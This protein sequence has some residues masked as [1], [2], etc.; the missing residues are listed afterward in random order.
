MF[1]KAKKLLLPSGVEAP[2]APSG[3]GVDSPAGITARRNGDPVGPMDL[4]DIP[5]GDQFPIVPLDEMLVVKRAPYKTEIFIPESAQKQLNTT[6]GVVVAVG[7]G[8]VMPVS[9]KRVA[10]DIEVGDYVMFGHYEGSTLNHGGKQYLLMPR[11]SVVAKIDPYTWRPDVPLDENEGRG[12][13]AASSGVF[14]GG[15]R[16]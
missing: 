10:M 12:V 5:M 7:Q 9:G 13:P 1:E 2:P 16:V 11:K 3:E 4:A 8:M 14:P 6:Y 15:A